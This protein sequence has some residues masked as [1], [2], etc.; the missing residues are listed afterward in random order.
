MQEWE[1]SMNTNTLTNYEYA[2]RSMDKGW[3]LM[4]F[5]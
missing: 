3:S 2:G 5:P 4:I 1:V